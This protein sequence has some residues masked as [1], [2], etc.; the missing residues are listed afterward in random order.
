MKLNSFQGPTT[1]EGFRLD[2]TVP[3]DSRMPMAPASTSTPM[4]IGASNTRYKRFQDR[5]KM[6]LTLMQGAMRW[7]RSRKDGT[8]NGKRSPPDA[9]T[10]IS[11]VP[12]SAL[13][14]S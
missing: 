9:L 4:H 5:T 10:Y 13:F 11:N 14:L 7:R 8:R 1:D 2:L 6:L 3:S 12:E